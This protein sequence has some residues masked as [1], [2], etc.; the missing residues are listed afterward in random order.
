MFVYLH[1]LFTT[2]LMKTPGLQ[3]FK[4]NFTKKKGHKRH[5]IMA[6]NGCS[7]VSIFLL[8]HLITAI[9]ILLRDG[10]SSKLHYSQSVDAPGQYCFAI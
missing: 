10:Q 2:Q 6:N 9:H 1:L 4:N 3:Q 8:G 7:I 5:H